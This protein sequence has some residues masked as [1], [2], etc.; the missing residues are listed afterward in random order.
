MLCRKAHLSSGR[1]STFQERN[2]R[3]SE[4]PQPPTDAAHY[5][6]Y[7]ELPTTSPPQ[8]AAERKRLEAK[9]EELGEKAESALDDPPPADYDSVHY[10][11]LPNEPE[12]AT[13]EQEDEVKTELEEELNKMTK[14]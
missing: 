1:E 8:T 2:L 10:D 9:L 3:R 5:D 12:S 13:T 6:H 7:E 4:L 11:D 14:L